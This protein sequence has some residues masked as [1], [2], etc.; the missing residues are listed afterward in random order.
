M[1]GKTQPVP[2]ATK[3]PILFNGPMVRGILEGRKTELIQT[4]PVLLDRPVLLKKNVGD[5][6]IL[7]QENCDT[8]RLELLGHNIT[9][10]DNATFSSDQI[11][12]RRRHGCQRTWPRYD[13]LVSGSFRPWPRDPAVIAHTRLH[14]SGTVPVIRR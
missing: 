9:V 13:R 7:I 3:R 11:L 4:R 5:S 8:T 2:G 12:D 10:L 6:A 1:N 14:I